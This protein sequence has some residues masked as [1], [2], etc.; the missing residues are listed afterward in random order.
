MDD[1]LLMEIR[2]NSMVLTINRF[3]ARNAMDFETATAI[4][5][6]LDQLDARDDLSIAVLTGA[7]G[8][9][10]SGM[11]LKGFLAG[12][13][14]SIPGRGFGGVTERPPRKVLIAAVEG[15]AL[16]GGFELV[17]ACDLVVASS[18]AKFGLPE[19]KRGLA[20]AA[21]G[22][23]RLP[24]HIPYHVAMEY[25]LTGDMLSAVRAYELGL[26]NRLTEPNG[27]LDEAL[28]LAAAV[29][30]NGPL[31]IAASKQVIAQSGDWI[32]EEMFALQKPLIDP[33][34]ASADAHEGATAFAEKR[35]P[36]WTGR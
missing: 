26:V 29:G 21:G 30:A 10:C 24:R 16:A 17:L 14:P 3:E 36:V 28:K 8:T 35:K 7:G 13:R 34:F 19:V 9:F 6:A 15:Y 22:L 31:A 4:A 5:A 2:G 32:H 33:V 20:A 25:A 1:T 23:M 27:A 11:D 12:K 18:T